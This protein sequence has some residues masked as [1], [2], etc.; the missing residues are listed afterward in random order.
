VNVIV[1]AERPI[2]D[3]VCT[4]DGPASS[5]LQLIKAKTNAKREI[6]RSM[7]RN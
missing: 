1:S 7:T 3:D 2:V 4:P 5:F 6:A